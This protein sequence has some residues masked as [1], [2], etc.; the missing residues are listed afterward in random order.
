M[1]DNVRVRSATTLSSPHL[2]VKYGWERA[3][4]RESPREVKNGGTMRMRR[5][6]RMLEPLGTPL[7][8]NEPNTL[9]SRSADFLEL[10]HERLDAADPN[11]VQ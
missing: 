2:R 8:L 11:K 10:R 5:M 7:L 9:D 4:R 6:E 1:T 3:R